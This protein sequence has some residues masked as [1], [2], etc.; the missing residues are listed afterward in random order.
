[1]TIKLNTIDDVNKFVNICIKYSQSDI[2]VKQDKQVIKGISILGIFSLDLLRPLIVTI[3]ND[4]DNKKIE[5]YK[6]IQKWEKMKI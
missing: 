6:N 5:F 3:D 2:C 1:M 4:D